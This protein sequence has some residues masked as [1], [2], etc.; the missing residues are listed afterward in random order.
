MRESFLTSVFYVLLFVFSNA[1]HPDCPDGL[2]SVSI[3][4]RWFRQPQFGGFIVAQGEGFYGMYNIISFYS[5][6]IEFLILC[7]IISH[8]IFVLLIYVED[9]CLNVLIRP[10]GGVPT[11]E[12]VCSG[13]AEFGVEHLS[14]ILASREYGQ[15][16]LYF[17]FVFLHIN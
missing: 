8:N 1:V 6:L 4:L 3:Q 2:T 7:M 11:T 16:V 17:P 13:V 15:Y 12:T 5:E 14:V 9:E 10:G